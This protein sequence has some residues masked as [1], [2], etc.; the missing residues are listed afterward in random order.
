[1]ENEL[2]D[3]TLDDLNRRV[4]EAILR[5]ERVGTD[6]DERRSLYRTVSEIEQQISQITTPESVD[7]GVA[8][9]GAVTAALDAGDWLRASWLA[10]SYLADAPADLEEELRV[11]IVEV[12]RAASNVPEPLVYPVGVDL[13]AL[14]AL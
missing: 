8:R 4:T 12:D 1:M 13:E 6:S 2:M 9:V 3:A 10:E 11:L 7:G 14:R 5:A